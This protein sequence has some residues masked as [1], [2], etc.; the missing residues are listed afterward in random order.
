MAKQE[1]GKTNVMRVLD[2]RKISY[3]P[4][5][6]PHGDEAVDGVTV[7]GL[8]GLA[9]ESVFKTLVARGASKVPYVFVIPVA[10]ELDLKKAAKSVGEKSIAML[11]VSELLSLTGYVRGGCS[12]LG[13]KKDYPV[14]IDESAN[15][16]P[17]IA[18]S[19]GKRGEQIMLAPADLVQAVKGTLCSISR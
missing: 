15:N 1:S 6:Y 7:A 3:T 2:Q 18:I 17:I 9:V 5:T 11:H 10:R 4:H 8:T 19:A 13:A 14:Y 16:W 12:P